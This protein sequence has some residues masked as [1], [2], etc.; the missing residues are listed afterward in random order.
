MYLLG[1]ADGSPLLE[2]AEKIG[3]PAW[4]LGD[5]VEKLVSH[6]LLSLES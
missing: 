2:I 5:T 1:Y 6:G 4:E 3:A